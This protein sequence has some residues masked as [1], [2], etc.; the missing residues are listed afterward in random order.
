MIIYI[1]EDI[2]MMKKR[3]KTETYIIV[4]MTEYLNKKEIKK[5]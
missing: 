2:M 5:F 3:K 1:T 4:H